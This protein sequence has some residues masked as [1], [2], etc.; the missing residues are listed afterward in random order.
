[1]GITNGYAT[2]AQYKAEHEI[3]DYVDDAMIERAIEAGSRIIDEITWR[4]F[5]VV[6]ETRYYTA[7]DSTILYVDDLT[8]VTTLKTDA[9]G[10]RVYEQTWQST[11]YDLMPFN[12]NRNGEPYM[13]IELAPNG[14]YSFPLTR[15]GVEIDGG[16]GW[17]A[18]APPLIFQACLM[19]AQRILKRKDTP[20][21]VSAAVAS[22]QFAVIVTE[23]K[24]D[25]DFMRLISSYIKGAGNG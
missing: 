19:A 9:D 22:G 5:Y 14:N 17:S 3:D 21:G 24:A 6:P 2:L 4:R 11:D 18:T 8:A 7:E 23:L 12:A 20:L 10:D 13:W 1:M 25:P 16:F 15:K